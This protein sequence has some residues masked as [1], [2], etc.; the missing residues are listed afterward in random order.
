MHIVSPASVVQ[1]KCRCTSDRRTAAAPCRAIKQ[2][3]SKVGLQLEA[4]LGAVPRVSPLCPDLPT[5]KISIP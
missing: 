3:A 2:C 4:L 5:Q 1:R